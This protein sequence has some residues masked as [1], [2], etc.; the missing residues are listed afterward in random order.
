MDKEA[1]ILALAALAQATRLEAFRLLVA[2]EPDGL[3]AGE[4]ARRLAVPHNTMST[5]LA[6]LTRAG[7]I[8]A[9]RRRTSLIYRASLDRVRELITYILKDCCGGHPE[10]C[11][12]LIDELTPCC[13]TKEAA[14][15]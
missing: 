3:A 12:P 6:V 11:M 8:Q 5:H 13:T 14:R 1:A 9:E 10:I 2:N 15:A 4:V 7:L